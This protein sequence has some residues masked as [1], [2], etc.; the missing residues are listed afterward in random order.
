MG[1]QKKRERGK[2]RTNN[3]LQKILTL[4]QTIPPDF[5]FSMKKQKYIYISCFYVS[6]RDGERSR[7]SVAS[8]DVSNLSNVK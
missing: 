5:A 7:G 2:N 8:N 4:L 3:N 6:H 1:E